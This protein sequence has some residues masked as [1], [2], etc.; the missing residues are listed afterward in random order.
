[1][2]GPANLQ[3]TLASTKVGISAGT[4]ASGTPARDG[5]ATFDGTVLEG[6]AWPP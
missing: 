3:R 5:P 2:H 4:V 6:Y 1:M